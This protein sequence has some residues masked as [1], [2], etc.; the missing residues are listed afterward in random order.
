MLEKNQIKLRQLKQDDI[1]FYHKWHL[2]MDNRRQLISHPFPIT[3][4]NE[5]KWFENILKN[6]SNTKIVLTIVDIVNDSPIGLFQLNQIN[7]VSGNAMLGILIGEKKLRGLGLGKKTLELGL[8]YAFNKLNLRKISLNVLEEN[9]NAK[10]LYVNTGFM[11]E[12]KFINE[13]YWDNKFLNVL[14][15]SIFKEQ[16]KSN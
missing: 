9:D 6:S 3:I 5:E 16:W 4:R 11:L 7:T 8:D 1:D 13:F 12:G 10:K 14:R 15:Y 2:D